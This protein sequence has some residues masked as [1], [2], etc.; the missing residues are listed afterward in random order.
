[1]KYAVIFILSLILQSETC[2]HLTT[3]NDENMSPT[4]LKYKLID[5][6]GDVAFCDPDYF[7]VA[8]PALEMQH[9]IELF[10][11]VKVQKEEFSEI[12]SRLKMSAENYSDSDKLKIYREQKR[13]SVIKLNESTNPYSFSM[14]TKEK[15][16][17]ETKWHYEGTITAS[18]KIAITK[19]EPYVLNCPICLPGNT[20]I[21]TPEGNVA[22]SNLKTGDEVIS[23]DRQNR[24]ITERILQT[25]KIQVPEF[26][27]MIQLDLQ[28]GRRISASPG[29]PL[30][31]GKL[32]EEIKTGD[33]VDGSTVKNIVLLFSKEFFT[34]DILP[35]GPTGFYLAN[36]VE[37]GSTLKAVSAVGEVK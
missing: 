4:Q 30:P 3:G 11:S 29:H 24:R 5:S 36:D 10:D 18:G 34:Y 16:G 12:S 9:A 21:K 1:M 14:N 33:A 20:L 22:V 17:S 13:L 31:G 25:S 23:F 2:D 19:K 7:P 26:H 32:F 27:E 15:D 28:D 6:L 37:V 8:R 35:D